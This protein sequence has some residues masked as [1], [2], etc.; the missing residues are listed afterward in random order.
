LLVEFLQNEVY[1]WTDHACKPCAEVANASLCTFA[2]SQGARLAT[3]DVSRNRPK[4]GIAGCRAKYNAEQEAFSYGAC[5]SCRDEAHDCG[6]IAASAVFAVSVAAYHAGCAA[7]CKPCLHKQNLVLNSA[8][9]YVA[10]DGRAQP[11]ARFRPTTRRAPGSMTW[12]HR[13]QGRDEKYQIL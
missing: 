7:G 10:A 9:N 6:D 3:Q 12:A 2:Q 4:L 13:F 1:D 11:A 5:E 8:H